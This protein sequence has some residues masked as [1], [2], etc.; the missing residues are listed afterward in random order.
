MKLTIDNMINF[1]KAAIHSMWRFLIVMLILN[2]TL[3]YGLAALWFMDLLGKSCRY[4]GSFVRNCYF[5][6]MRID[7][8]SE[9]FLTMWTIPFMGIIGGILL[10]FITAF[11]LTPVIWPF[12]YAG[13]LLY[14]K[15]K[16]GKGQDDTRD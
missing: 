12:Y 7:V 16:A 14:A 4:D 11:M 2:I 3:S 1:I 9:F 15:F 13:K 8:L 10:P 5:L 6:G